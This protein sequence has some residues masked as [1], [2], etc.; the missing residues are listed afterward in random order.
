MFL[1][2]HERYVE[3]YRGGRERFCAWSVRWRTFARDGVP[4]SRY[5]SIG[6]PRWFP[7]A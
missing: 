6:K 4:I 1:G 5:R 7:R 2:T 3:G